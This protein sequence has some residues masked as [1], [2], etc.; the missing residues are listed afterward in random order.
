VSNILGYCSFVIIPFFHPNA[1]FSASQ[2]GS[3]PV[4]RTVCAL[5]LRLA[6][7]HALSPPAY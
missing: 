5:S 3:I 7:E 1:P 4:Q 2:R 6:V